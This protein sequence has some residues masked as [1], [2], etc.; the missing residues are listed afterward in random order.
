MKAV[1]AVEDEEEVPV[2][3][4]FIGAVENVKTSDTAWHV[5]LEIGS[6]IAQCKLDTGAEAN[7]LPLHMYQKVGGV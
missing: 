6:R 5:N 7:V 1:D 2:D 3:T 4:L